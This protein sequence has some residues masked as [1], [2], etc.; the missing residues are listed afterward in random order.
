MEVETDSGLVALGGTRQRAALAF[1][2]LHANRV[3]P[4]SQLLDALWPTDRAPMTARKILQNAVWRLRRAL[5]HAADPEDAPELVTRAPGYMVRVRPDQVDLLVF[6]QRVVEGRA[7]LVADDPLTASRVLR[8]ALSLW[9]GVALADL[10]EDGTAWPQ[11]TAVQEKRL[12]VMEDRFEAELA[13]GGHHAVL[14]ELEAFVEAEPLRERASQQLMIALYR[15]GRQAEALDVYSRVR[16]A[17]V[18]GLGLEPGRQMQLLQQSVLTQ[19]PALD[20]PVEVTA[21]REHGLAASGPARTA[22]AGLAPEGSGAREAEEVTAPEPAPA[23]RTREAVEVPLNPRQPA[24][25]LML[26]FQLGA[27]FDHLPP[28]DVDRV[29]D[30]VSQLA[31][32]KIEEFGGLAAASIGSVQLGYFAHSPGPA[33]GADRAVR[34]GTAVRDCLSIPAGPLTPLA[35][36]VRGLDVHAAVTTGEA[37]VCSWTVAGA[38]RPWI[39][40]D[41]VDSCQDM[42]DQTPGGEVQ[43]CD[44]TRRLTEPVITYHHVCASPSTWQV[45]T[46]GGRTDG[47]VEP[48]AAQAG[49]RECELDLMRGLLRRTQQRSTPHLIT[50][51]GESG[52]GKTRLLMEFRR[53]LTA[54]RDTVRV[55]TGAV[56]RPGSG[57]PLSVPAEM[58]AAYCGITGRDTE[59]AA[60]R[61]ADATLTRL[62]GSEKGARAMLSPLRPLIAVVPRSHRALPVHEVLA[63]WRDFLAKAALEQP[64]V[65]IW[66][67]LHQADGIVLETVEQLTHA[68]ANVPLLNVVGARAQLLE[69]RPDWAGGRQHTMTISLA[70]VDGDALDRLLK[71]L[72]VPDGSADVA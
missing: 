40:G 14:R 52:L 50:V 31:R 23:A 10:V 29:L 67:D 12:D 25:I 13:C 51:L 71:S 54:E 28:K 22:S 19:D 34:A 24:T 16:A 18:G 7:A 65:L 64:L 32:E 69:R 17:L 46:V 11:L 63:A 37:V 43:V 45:R 53:R 27:E 15:C 48:C 66:D 2:L 3:V 57:S 36:V 49:E 4:T 55:L 8:D 68:C 44:T 5:A 33:H 39:G 6:Q 41:L 59:A 9:Q 60:L 21:R 35:P 58:F 26:R 42:L 56:P 72:L 70:P 61:K 47:A 1:L 38:V 20:L 30:A 62:T